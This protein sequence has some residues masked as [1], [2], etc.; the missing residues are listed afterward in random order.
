MTAASPWPLLPTLLATALVYVGVVFALMG[1]CAR[2]SGWSLLFAAYPC[3]GQCP[4]PRQWFSSLI[5]RGWFG[6]NNGIVVSADARALHLTAWPVILAPTHGPVRIPWS[7][8][9]AIRYKKRWYGESWE[10]ETRALPDLRWG[11]RKRAFLFLR[12]AVVAAGVAL[13]DAT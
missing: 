6:Y 4:R 1:L 12:P 7:E 9:A 11:L 3:D 10:V 8:V 13:E 2:V 5:F